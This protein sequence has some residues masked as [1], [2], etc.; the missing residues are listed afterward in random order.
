M[1]L[2]AVLERLPIDAKT[3]AGELFLERS[4][5]LGSYWPLGRVGARAL[6]RGD[7]SSVV[8]PGVAQR[9]LRHL[10]ALDW[11]KA[12]GATF[13]AASIARLTGDPALDVDA[14]TRSEVI[15]RLARVKA[16]PSWSELL[17]RPSGLPEGDLKRVLG[18]ALPA[19]LRLA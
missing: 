11:E 19:G 5:K 18:E 2:V 9:W 6:L 10:L 4:D 15:E 17:L 8:P 7:A 1:H 16:P 3:A 13:A 12:E 14:S